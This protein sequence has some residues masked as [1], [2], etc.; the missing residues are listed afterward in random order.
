[1][2]HLDAALV[3][4][5]V[6]ANGVILLIILAILVFEAASLWKI[7][8]KAGRP[9]WAILI[10]IYNSYVL[11][12]IAGKSG[13]WLLLFFI[14]FVNAVALI[15]ILNELARSFGRGGGFTIGLVLLPYIFFP[16][17]GFGSDQYVGPGGLP[18]DYPSF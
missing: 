15:I 14:P 3:A 5:A 8:T 10:P 1:M 12:K 13:W 11:I 9:G 2:R 17:L 18:S 4:S 6:G 16:I 7:L